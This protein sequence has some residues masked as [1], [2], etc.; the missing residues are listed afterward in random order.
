MMPYATILLE[1][2]QAAA[3]LTFLRPEKRNALSLQMMDEIVDA[4][5]Q[6]RKTETAQTLIV[7]GGSQF[8]SAGADLTEALE[9]KTPADGARFFGSLHRVNNALEGLNKPVIAAIEGAC[10][11]GGCELALACDVRIAGEGAKF[12]IT[13]TRIGTVAGAGGTQRLPRIV[14]MANALSLLFSADPIDADE[15]FR[16][17]LINRKVEGGGALA[18]SRSLAATYAKR[19]PLGLA[20]TKLAVRRGLQMDV[21]SALEFEKSLVTSIYATADKQ[22]G[23]SAFLEK[24]EPRFKGC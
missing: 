23:I 24:R 6:V 1:F 4:C 11:T 9:V 12:A 20:F 15:A 2:D 14:G 17:G 10:M 19:A 21:D 7:T 16:I 5:E 22:E 13:S 18:A 3:I 8:F